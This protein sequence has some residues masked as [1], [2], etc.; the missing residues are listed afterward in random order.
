MPR[1]IA[2]VVAALILPGGF[3][4][5]FGAAL[6]K[7]I[8]GTERGRNLIELARRRAPAWLQSLGGPSQRL[9]A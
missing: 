9:A 4:A 1:K 5:L 3:I 7:A 6:F 2:L 8:Q